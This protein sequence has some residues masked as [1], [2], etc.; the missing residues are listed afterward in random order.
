MKLHHSARNSVAYCFKEKKPCVGWVH[1]YFKDC[2][3]NLRDHFSFG[4]GLI[5]LVA[6]AVAEVPQIIT[7]FR[8]KSSHGVSLLFLLTW[9]LGD[10]FNLVGCLLEP[11]TLPTQF[12]TALLYT[13]ST[14]VL[15]LQSMYYDHVY[16]W[17]KC[18]RQ[19]NRVTQQVEDEKEPLKPK[20]AESAI[21]IPNAQRRSPARREFYYTSARSLA[22]S[23]TPPFRSYLRAA[24]SGPSAMGLDEQSSSEDE[25]TPVSTNKPTSQP[26]PIPRPGTRGAVLAA[27][28]NLPVRSN[29]LMQA[30]MGFTAE[31]PLHGNELEHSAFGQWLGWLM[32]AIYMGGRI[33]QII[34]NIKRGSVEGLNPLMF[35]FAL[36]ANVTY[37]AS[38]LVRS[39]DWDKIKAN[40]PWL[41]D[42]VVCVALDLFIILQYVYYKY[43]RKNDPDNDHYY[44]E[45]DKAFGSS[46]FGNS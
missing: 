36:I 1:K 45:A 17:W 6:W 41:L 29:A 14:V 32:A 31:R 44:V 23:G 13:T 12:Y 4:F 34:L 7:N 42:A 5:S 39:T 38:I 16:S 40:L 21:P 37:V 3:C 30:Y 28:L 18:R 46:A 33:P 27:S 8:T 25:A 24:R 20:P 26:K 15:V 19:Y 11:A 2:L 43:M 9:V 35:I 22:G 10:I